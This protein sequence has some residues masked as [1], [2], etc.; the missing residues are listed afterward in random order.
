TKIM[1]ESKQ[2]K[3]D[4]DSGLGESQEIPQGGIVERYVGPKGLKSIL[5]KFMLV[6]IEMRGL[7]P[8]PPEK[9]T[10]TKYY[11]VLTLFG[12]SFFSLLP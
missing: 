5:K 2:T 8:I 9:R 7:E 4:F 6:G 12:G 11:N 10:H 1:E 3:I